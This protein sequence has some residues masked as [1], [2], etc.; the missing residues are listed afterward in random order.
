MF[1]AIG[2]G[3]RPLTT[4]CYL[5]A[6][7]SNQRHVRYGL[8]SSVI[9][10]ALSAL[11]KADVKIV[12]QSA[13]ITSRPVGPSQRSYANAAITVESKLDPSSMLTLL[14]AIEADF[15]PRRGQKWS[16][17]VLDLD[18]ILWSGG[19]FFS[20]NPSLVIPHPLMRQREFV[21]KPAAE[22]AA[23]WQDPISGRTISQLWSRFSRNPVPVK[24]T[25]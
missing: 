22:I 8:P 2:G 4:S 13:T 17:R 23:T 25:P 5:I 14:K 1:K 19:P 24:K 15:G 12:K 3:V 7:G 20:A 18:I 11:A 10:H 9:S 21:L 16:R 6:L